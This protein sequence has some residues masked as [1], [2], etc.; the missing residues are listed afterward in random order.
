MKKG[1]GS[2]AFLVILIISVLV[3]VLLAVWSAKQDVAEVEKIKQ[4]EVIQDQKAEELGDAM[5]GIKADIEQGYEDLDS[6]ISE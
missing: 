4:D 2:G 3:V 5:K 6:Q 1:F